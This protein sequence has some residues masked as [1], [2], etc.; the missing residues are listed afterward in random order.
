MKEEDPS[1]CRTI[2]ADNHFGFKE[3]LLNEHG[4][5][6]FPHHLTT[7]LTTNLFGGNHEEKRY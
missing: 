1:D 2:S 5:L 4:T 6:L 3:K 7:F